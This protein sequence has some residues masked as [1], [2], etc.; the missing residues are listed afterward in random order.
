MD[1]IL[2][3]C[4]IYSNSG[5]VVMQ[6]C[7]YIREG[8]CLITELI[9]HKDD[10]TMFKP[11]A[12]GKSA[13]DLIYDYMKGFEGYPRDLDNVIK[14]FISGYLDAMV[15]LGEVDPAKANVILLEWE[16]RRAGRSWT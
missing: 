9:C 1:S 5:D 15:D 10:C 8:H 13:V 11:I 7:K 2:A 3:I 12:I 6:D 4:S 16:R 14:G